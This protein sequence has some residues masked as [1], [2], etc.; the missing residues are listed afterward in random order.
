VR[1]PQLGRIEKEG[2]GIQTA[3]YADFTDLRRQSKHKTLLLI[4][5][6]LFPISDV[7]VVRG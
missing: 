6:P 1:I 3:D 7:R 2:N 5:L 4:R